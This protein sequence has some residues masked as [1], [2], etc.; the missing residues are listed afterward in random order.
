MDYTV[1]REK[2]ELELY[3]AMRNYL[4]AC[5]SEAHSNSIKRGIKAAKERKAKE[6]EREVS[7]ND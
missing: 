4:K 5:K 2:T 1:I 6:A 7:N 3:S